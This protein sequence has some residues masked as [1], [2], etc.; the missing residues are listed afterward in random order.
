MEKI[1]WQSIENYKEI[2]K[3]GVAS[4]EKTPEFAIKGLDESELKGKSSRRDF[5]KMMGFSVSAVA[6]VSSCQM[7]VR[8]AIPLLNRPKDLIPG[9]P[10][11]YA[12]TF[13]D[14]D[15]FCSV[16]V[17]TR[18]SRPIKIEGNELC[19]LS[20][21]GTTARVQA[22]VLNLYDDAR[23]KNP[24]KNSEKTDWKSLDKEVTK[25]LN[26][27]KDMGKEVIFMTSTIIIIFIIL[28][29]YFNFDM[30]I[31]DLSM[32]ALGFIFLLLFSFSLAVVIAVL[33]SFMQTVGKLIGFAMTALMFG[34]AIFYSLDML[35][36]NLQKILLYN[37]LTHLMEMIHGSYFKSLDDS[38]VSY[39]Y[40]S[41]WTL[42]L[43]YIGL[44]LYS[45][46]EKRIV[47]L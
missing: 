23:L 38:L 39:E 28:G 33:N 10:N 6:L 35:A 20:Q 3:E 14:G 30:N 12:S 31:K 21:S 1:Y 40:V 8:K 37:P 7:P 46:L 26:G 13:F 17:K 47:A 4:N 27:F 36:P 34:S 32:V 16:L 24:L 41:L 2:Q 42:S 29:Y 9:V 44:W 45:K 19:P 25:K 5:L 15:E 18:E 11:F 22:S 43:L